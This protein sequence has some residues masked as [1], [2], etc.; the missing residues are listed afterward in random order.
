MVSAL[1]VW[2]DLLIALLLLPDDKL[3]SLMVGITL[4][5]GR[6][7][8]D[9]PVAIAGMLMASLPMFI[10]YVVGQRYFAHGLSAGAIKG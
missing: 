7:S 6:Y 4:F 8:N 2:N 9:V 3:R 10:L 5:G 1:W